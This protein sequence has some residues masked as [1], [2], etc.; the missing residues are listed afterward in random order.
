MVRLILADENLMLL[1]IHLAVNFDLDLSTIAFFSFFQSNSEGECALN[2]IV[3]ICIAILNFSDFQYKF[4][5][6]C[7]EAGAVRECFKLLRGLK[8]CTHELSDKRVSRQ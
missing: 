6:A 5:K 1:Q 8:T 7:W 3:S 4:C 2:V